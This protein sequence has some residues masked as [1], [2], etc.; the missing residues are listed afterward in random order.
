MWLTLGYLINEVT[1]LGKCGFI[2]LIFEF[3]EIFFDS[4]GSS[5]GSRKSDHVHWHRSLRC[6]CH[7]RLPRHRLRRDASKAATASAGYVD[8]S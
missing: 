3:S 1:Y 6:R 4:N 5:N 2:F 8:I 7:C